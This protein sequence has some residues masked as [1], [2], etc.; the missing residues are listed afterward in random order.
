MRCG[1]CRQDWRDAAKQHQACDACSSRS[2]RKSKS[3]CAARS[4]SSSGS[5]RTSAITVSS[6][7]VIEPVYHALASGGVVGN[8][9]HATIIDARVMANATLTID[10]YA[11]I[12]KLEK[13]GFS[14]AQAE[15]IVEALGEINVAQLATT[16]DLRDLELR[17]YK[18][19]GGILIAHGLGTAALTVTLLQ[20]LQ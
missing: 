18:Y 2:R 6:N 9:R 8:R 12:Q 10:K 4:C 15:G 3:A 11:V 13:R 19:F 20:L 5:A 16:H 7:F 14:Q 1:F 17:L